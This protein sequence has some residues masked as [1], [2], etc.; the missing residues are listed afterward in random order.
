MPA[1]A[2][3]LWHG[4]RLIHRVRQQAGSYGSVSCVDI[5]ADATNVGVLPWDLGQRKTR[6]RS[7]LAR[8]GGGSVPWISA[9]TPRS[10]ASRLLRVR[11]FDLRRGPAQIQCRTAL[12]K[13][14]FCDSVRARKRPANRFSTRWA[15]L[16][17]QRPVAHPRRHAA[18]TQFPR[19][20]HKLHTA[21]STGHAL[22]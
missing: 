4:F 21:L 12:A 3:C 1:Q 17:K 6:C 11:V 20:T 13:A 19:F 22:Q 16:K 15:A 5:S 14:V 9:D 2:V 10:P 8:D 18:Y 7:A